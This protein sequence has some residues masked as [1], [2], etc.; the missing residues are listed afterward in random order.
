MSDD[1][2]IH[3]NMMRSSPRG[4]ATDP[5]I[6]PDLVDP[7]AGG[8]DGHRTRRDD[9]PGHNSQRV[10]TPTN[11]TLLRN[12]R[13]A[14]DDT[15]ED[16]GLAA[17]SAAG[18]VVSLRGEPTDPG[19][20]IYEIDQLVAEMTEQCHILSKD[21]AVRVTRKLL[22]YAAKAD[23][24]DCD[25]FF[26]AHQDAEVITPLSDFVQDVRK[27][28]TQLAD[29]NCPLRDAEFLL[30]KCIKQAEAPVFENFRF[31]SD[32]LEDV[33]TEANKKLGLLQEEISSL[34]DNKKA[35]AGDNE[36]RVE[37]IIIHRNTLTTKPPTYDG[38]FR[39]FPLFMSNLKN[40]YNE[41]KN[42][43][44][45]IT[46]IRSFL[47]VNPFKTEPTMIGELQGIVKFDDLLDLIGRRLFNNIRFVHTMLKDY[48][49]RT[50]I[51]FYDHTYA[52]L[53]SDILTDFEIF[54]QLN[55]TK[56]MSY[57]LLCYE[58]L[59]LLPHKV[60]S[61]LRR[62][63]I[64]ASAHGEPADEVFRD[65]MITRLTNERECLATQGKLAKPVA[66]TAGAA[67][68]KRQ[69]AAANAAVLKKQARPCDLP[70]CTVDDPHAW[71]D[72]AFLKELPPKERVK[73][74]DNCCL[75]CGSNSHLAD[76][77]KRKKG[78][79]CNLCS[80][81]EHTALFCYNK[82]NIQV[83]QTSVDI[84]KKIHRAVCIN[85]AAE[86]N[87]SLYA[88]PAYTSESV[89]HDL[90]NSALPVQTLSVAGN[91]HM[92]TMYDSGSQ[93]NLID[94]TL[95]RKLNLSY[96]SVNSN[97]VG[98]GME[99]GKGE[100]CRRMYHLKITCESGAVHQIKAIGFR[101]T[102]S[103]AA[104]LPPDL[105]KQVLGDKW[106]E[107]NFDSTSGNVHLLL[108]VSSLGL[109]PSIV[110]ECSNMILVLVECL[111]KMFWPSKQ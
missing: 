83:N 74:F 46:I 97:V 38:N 15:M 17:S 22:P 56:Y 44:D 109:F 23:M 11:G 18:S 106:E 90:T 8:T 36:G 104:N 3:N 91:I 41:H 32:G 108:G 77:C 64:S 60:E 45:E 101:K 20:F 54:K 35:K 51:R 57:S 86:D 21:Q 27:L 37:K 102:L 76:G 81:T 14:T 95:A 71:Y 53:L 89:F 87:N 25:D 42:N 2:D 100:V 34:S 19:Q 49:D 10:T 5:D 24:D 96:S 7:D 61:E 29:E 50:K 12:S 6:P 63:F 84:C 73:L 40:F 59:D 85:D 105:G 103:K 107:G 1:N 94:D 92:V 82:K 43:N 68:V 52:T 4:S 39:K 99:N 55:L 72:C 28:E 66:K 88:N 58:I 78:W 80:S 69:S 26:R 110:A 67:T 70:K 30:R 62:D 79:K 31:N 48:R 47:S 13:N 33:F 75:I 98:I 16:R 111:R 9:A 65:L 93:C